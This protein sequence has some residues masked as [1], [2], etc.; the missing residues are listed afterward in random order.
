MRTRDPEAGV[1][2]LA[3]AE[4]RDR[5]AFALFVAF[6]V[7][8]YA[9]PGAW[10]PALDSLR[11]ALSLSMGALALLVLVRVGRGQP[12]HFDGARGLALIGF[13]ALGLASLAWTVAPERTLDWFTNLIKVAATYF[14]VVNLVTTPRRLRI[15]CLALV[16][17]SLVTSIGTLQQYFGGIDL[18][19]GFRARWLG[20]YGDPNY[21]AE[22]LLIVVPVAAAFA[23]RTETRGVLRVLS[24]AAILLGVTTIVLTF[25]RG[26][27][28]GLVLTLIVWAIR[29]RRQRAKALF[30]ASVLGVGMVVLAP[31]IYWERAE[32]VENFAK[33]PS[34]QGRIYAWHVASRISA[35]RPLLGVGGGAF[36]DAWPRYAP[37]QS[38]RALVAH[39]IFLDTVGELGWIGLFLFLVWVGSAT[40]AVFRAGSDPQV[41]WLARG[42][43][44]STAGFLLCNCFAGSLATPHLFLLIGLAAAS[45]RVTEAGDETEAAPASAQPSVAVEAA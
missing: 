18:S 35:D 43:G 44:A 33:D 38:E 21:L 17:A 2:R 40:G 14:L 19:Q 10:I 32:S 24:L 29:E 12:F 1:A 7:Q 27:F 34:A 9:V 20:T 31:D 39:N 11:L 41:G 6:V 26:G 22:Y 23:A 25:S 30:L 4:G 36:F 13:S 5:W 15:V 45:E 3:L 28:F 42:L 16:L 37:P 8:L